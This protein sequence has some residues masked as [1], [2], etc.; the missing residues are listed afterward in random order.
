MLACE[1]ASKKRPVFDILKKRMPLLD[2]IKLKQSPKKGVLTYRY[3]NS[4]WQ[5]Q[6]LQLL[7]NL[8]VETITNP[9]AEYLP[10]PYCLRKFAPN[11]AENHIEICKNILNKPKPPPSLTKSPN[12]KNSPSLRK[13]SFK[14]VQRALSVIS[15]DCPSFKSLGNLICVNIEESQGGPGIS[16]NS[17]LVENLKK[18]K[19]R[20]QN[21]IKTVA[22]TLR[23]VRNLNYSKKSLKSCSVD[24]DDSE[25]VRVKVMTER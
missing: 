1:W 3:T 5:Q 24:K 7:S 18:K 16:P 11:I 9:Y 12:L 2:E 15:K 25:E 23:K 20:R 19:K 17:D 22:K 10:C 6:H 4:K 8:R 13:D 21:K 14:V